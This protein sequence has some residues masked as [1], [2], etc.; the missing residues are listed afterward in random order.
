MR[1]KRVLRV[2]LVKVSI[3]GCVLH[4][5]VDS[6]IAKGLQNVVLALCKILQQS[7]LSQ[8]IVIEALHEGR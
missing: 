1:S 6:M 3:P 8:A 2:F 4:I 5:K 7:F